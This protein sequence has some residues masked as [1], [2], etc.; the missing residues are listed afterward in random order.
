MPIKSLKTFAVPPER[1]IL[2]T[3]PEYSRWEVYS[4]G[5]RQ[6]LEKLPH[7]RL[8]REELWKLASN[9]S[10]STVPDALVVTGHQPVWH[11]CGVW[12]KDLIGF[13]FARKT[14]GAFLHLI[15]DHDIK[16]TALTVPTPNA[17]GEWVQKHVSL[18]QECLQL[19]L[20]C[21]PMITKKKIEAF[22]ETVRRAGNGI[23]SESMW[24]KI[25]E[26]RDQL[27]ED[28]KNGA[29]FIH[30]FQELINQ[31]LGLKPVYLRVSD[32]SAGNS[33]YSFATM[34]IAK[35]E[36]F[37]DLYNHGIQ[38]AKIPLPLLFRDERNKS[39]QLPFWILTGRENR[40]DLLVAA[41]GKNM[42][43]L[44][45][46]TKEIGFLHEN[47]GAYDAEELKGLLQKKNYRLRP[48]AVTLTLFVRLFL[49]DWF[50]HGVGGALYEAVGDYLLE[51]FWEISGLKYGVATA[52]VVLPLDKSYHAASK[53]QVHHMKHNPE[54]YMDTALLESEPWKSMIIHKSSA[55]S[56]A[57][58][59]SLSTGHRKAA[60]DLMKT[61]N[62]KLYECIHE[63][64]ERLER[65]DRS[66]LVC[67]SREYFY[68]FF[69]SQ[70]LLGLLSE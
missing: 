24:E 48:K 6:L 4:E 35:A 51:H 30:A 9:T 16:D 59:Q 5:N 20:E 33:F 65:E 19:P 39:Y 62:R 31:A 64:C 25:D 66:R 67:G 55:I 23:L 29:A 52:T 3:W 47:Q 44:Y 43:Q 8:A 70:T 57:V 7:R 56:D 61:I 12:V 40:E 13:N 37:S 10:D 60:W 49:A 21:R 36:K 28:Y 27:F 38:R 17:E 15:L 26:N 53:H 58:D 50:I 46:K 34:L 14:G 63:K 1:N 68:G 69:S 45:T 11:H 54:R 2:F 41:G 42:I 32:L 18:E 22:M